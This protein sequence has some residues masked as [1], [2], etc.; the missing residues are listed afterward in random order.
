M[1]PVMFGTTRESAA[2]PPRIVIPSCIK[3]K[4]EGSVEGA[5]ALETNYLY[6]VGRSKIAD[7]AGRRYSS[8][9]VWHLADL[10]YSRRS[11]SRPMR[12]SSTRCRASSPLHVT[13][14]P[15]YR[16]VR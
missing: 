9:A 6:K 4:V 5:D 2:R 15:G 7:S 10:T 13:A 11:C 1:R 12:R 8:M 3:K 14:E 16:L